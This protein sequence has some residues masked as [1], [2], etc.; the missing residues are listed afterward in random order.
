MLLDHDYHP[1]TVVDVLDETE[2]ARSFV[3]DIPPTLQ[4]TF[5]YRAGQFCTFRAEIGGHT[6]VRSYSMSSSPD[7]GESFTTTVKRVPGGRMSNWMNDALDSGSTIDVMRP[8]GLFVLRET[9][10]DL[11]AFAGGSGI[12]PVISLIKTAL[13]T[14]GRRIHL[15]YANRTPDSVIFGAELDRMAATHHERLSVHHHYDSECGLLEPAGCAALA[16]RCRTAD[17]Y[18]CGPAPYMEVVQAGLA[19]HNVSPDQVFIERF[20][21]PPV[22]SADTAPAS[23]PEVLVIRLQRRNHTLTY[24]AGD[25]V[26]EAARRAGLRPP[27]SC[28]SGNCAS[29]MAHLDQGTVTMRTNNALSPDEVKNGWVLTCQSIPTSREAVVNYDA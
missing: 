1:L 15:V 17:F 14:T 23:L 11:V 3:L 19:H 25:T 10:E 12:T 29:C 21:T 5:T 27:S 6:V 2:D 13:A 8:T 26:L 7:L 20:V 16:A 22:P 9:D 28:E 24:H 18:L 4:S